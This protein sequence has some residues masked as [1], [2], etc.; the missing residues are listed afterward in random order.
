[1]LAEKLSAIDTSRT[2]EDVLEQDVDELVHDLRGPLAVIVAFA[3]SLEGARSEDRARF[4]DRL[5]VNAHRALSVLEEFSAL[6]DLRSSEV[7]P[8]LRPMDLAEVVRR[9]YQEIAVG[10]QRGLE[11]NCVVPQ[12]GLPMM[13]DSDLLGLGIRSVLRKVAHGLTAPGSVRLHVSGDRDLGRVE[14]RVSS[15]SARRYDLEALPVAE[16]EILRR[17]VGLH[18]GRLVFENDGNELVIGI[19]IPRQPR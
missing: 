3:E 15:E 13:G 6:C 12:D 2:T 16:H 7:E 4:S 9:S 5:V 10:L 19:C 11:I 17:V 8:R 1:M 14:M 18:G